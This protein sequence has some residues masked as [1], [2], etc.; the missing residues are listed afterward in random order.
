MRG[1]PHAHAHARLLAPAKLS[2][3]GE[4]ELSELL[5]QDAVPYEALSPEI[6]QLAGC[7]EIY[8]TVE[9]IA[10]MLLLWAA[11][12]DRAANA[13]LTAEGRTESGADVAAVDVS[14]APAVRFVALPPTHAALGARRPSNAG[15]FTLARR[16]S[17][18]SALSRLPSNTPAVRADG[19]RS[20]PVSLPTRQFTNRAP[21]EI[22][23]DDGESEAAAASPT[24]TSPS[25]ASSPPA[26]PVTV[27]VGRRGGRR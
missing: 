13:H 23:K 15:A 4:A 7:G 20:P 12:L 25:G 10:H 16:G 6:G 1:V 14:A 19:L 24:L 9:E 18:V 22:V 3:V 27:R 8:A 26:A 11:E 5:R 2:V 17:N 21:L